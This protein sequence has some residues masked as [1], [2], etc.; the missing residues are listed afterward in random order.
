MIKNKD[1]TILKNKDGYI[2]KSTVIN[3]YLASTQ[4]Y[5][6]RY[7]ITLSGVTA[8]NPFKFYFEKPTG[9]VKIVYTSNV[10]NFDQ[11]ISPT[12]ESSSKKVYTFGNLNSVITFKTT[13]DSNYDTGD[14]FDFMN[15][16]PNLET[17]EFQ[18]SSFSNNISYKTFP[19]RLK[20][21]HIY[22][23]TITGNI[24]TIN[25]IVNLEDLSLN[26]CPVTGNVSN[27]PFSNLRK[28]SL[29][30]VNTLNCNINNLFN[31]VN[32]ES[33]FL[34]GSSLVTGNLSTI[35]VSKLNYFYYNKPI[36]SNLITG[37]VT[38][39]IFSTGLTLFTF[40]SGYY[41]TGDL[42]NWD[43]SDTKCTSILIHDSN[44]SNGIISGDLSNWVLPDTLKDI[45]ISGLYQVTRVPLNYS[46]TNLNSF[47]I[48][49]MTSL[50]SVTGITFPTGVTYFSLT[51]NGNLIDDINNIT[52]PNSFSIN[53]SSNKLTGNIHD[54]TIPSATTSLFLYGNLNITGY[55]SGL[56][57]NSAITNLQLYNNNL[58]GNIT[59]TVLP[60][61]LIYFYL[62][63]N[64]IYIDFDEGVFNTN[65]LIYLTLGY[66]SGMTGN[67]DNF[68]INKNMQA[69]DLAYTPIS[70][71]MGNFPAHKIQSFAIRNCS[72]N[73]DIS[74]WYGGTGVTT[75]LDI[76]NN[77][78]LSGDTTSWIISGT[79]NLFLDNTGLSG[80]LKHYNV[81]TLIASN[82]EISSNINTDFNLINRAFDFRVD[83][84]NIQGTL[85]GV[86]LYSGISNFY[87]N[88]NTGVTGSNA[89]IDYL[90]V[91]KKYFTYVNFSIN[92]SGIG[93]TVSGTTEQLGSLGTYGGNAWDLT[94]AQV[95]FLSN[96]LDYTGSGSNTP[97]NQKEKIYWMEN[98]KISSTN[99]AKRYINYIITY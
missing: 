5:Y 80:A 94:E 68:I 8:T 9:M 2:L 50:T 64:D 33:F 30:N 6:Y 59:G 55:I 13:S 86:T 22:D 4:S 19:S 96:G 76:R 77:P 53:L 15:Q 74:S 12:S 35:D 99:N 60:T 20:Y 51:N 78:N 17:L 26:S 92:I 37:D 18:H 71:D 93:D 14:L 69:L 34:N 45:Q 1:D 31:N 95:N 79:T 3:S 27:I 87:I 85:S 52:L 40:I 73:C 70:S 16:F 82:S 97:W 25:N 75:S 32:L 44:S 81:Y 84:C 28:I 65:N 46:N 98:A 36:T 48:N 49:N 42:T 23:S 89:F 39:W 88:G 41:I 57:F 91:N 29:N 38:N 66:L 47:N 62:S 83:N 54:F 67:I 72:L 11:L 43:F 21:F 7:T 10:T 58:Y 56:T 61:S 90:F 24:N 63:M